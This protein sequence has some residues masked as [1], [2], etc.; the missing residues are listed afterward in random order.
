M[1]LAIGI[2]LSL[3][4]I[5]T[6]VMVVQRTE[7]RAWRVWAIFGTVLVLSAVWLVHITGPAASDATP[8]QTRPETS[9]KC[10]DSCQTVA[11]KKVKQFKQG[12]LGTAKD[13]KVPLKFRKA[14]E[15]WKANHRP[16]SER[17]LGDW[18][19]KVMTEGHCWLGVVQSSL[20][21]GANRPDL[22]ADVTKI[23]VVC[24]SLGVVGYVPGAGWVAI[25]RGASQCGAGVWVAKNNIWK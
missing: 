25:V 4:V 19:D 21:Y 9:S 10:A 7:S 2:I 17:G 13:R 23:S 12:K 15:K 11:A 16:A 22:A 1:D 3:I 18:W 6:T 24:G 14:L 8:A 5:V 20:C